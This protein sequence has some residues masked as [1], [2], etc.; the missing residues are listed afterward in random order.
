VDSLSFRIHPPLWDLID[1]QTRRAL[2]D[3]DGR[4]HGLHVPAEAAQRILDGVVGPMIEVIGRQLRT[5]AARDGAPDGPELLML[6]GGFGRSDYL[7]A[8]INAEFGSEARLLLAK[9]PG[10]A[11]MV[12]A[13]HYC[14][15]PS[16]IRARTARYTVGYRVSKPFR[17]GVDPVEAQTR[18][19][20]GQLYCRTRFERLI[21]RGESVEVDFSHSFTHT[22]LTKNQETLKF[23]FYVT[24]D[25]SD[26]A[27]V[28]DTSSKRL[29][30]VTLDITESAGRPPSEREVECFVYFGNTETR[31]RARNPRT[32]QEV[33]TSF[34]IDYVR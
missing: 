6:V 24:P 29:G 14:Y 30:E 25:E 12:G 4:D 27:W 2:A 23:V 10:L 22:P 34:E 17:Q 26:P 20:D 13:V 11:V 8:R 21:G 3:E 15:N 19:D 31:V 28:D 7:Q 9:D 1:E 33:V 18:D 5:M 16:V 32:G